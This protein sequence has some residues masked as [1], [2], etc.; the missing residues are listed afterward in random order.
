MYCIGDLFILYS[1]LH[2]TIPLLCQCRVYVL[3]LH[4]ELLS[5]HG[6]IYI[7]IYKTIWGEFTVKI[8]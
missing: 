1:I 3:D 5:W 7:Y 8:S 6:Y 2:Q 4:F